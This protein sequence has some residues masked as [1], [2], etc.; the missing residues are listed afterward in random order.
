[1]REEAK[2]REKQLLMDFSVHE[3]ELK[4]RLES[5]DAE[6]RFVEEFRSLRAGMELEL[7]SLREDNVNLKE[8]IEQQRAEL[9]RWEFFLI[10]CLG[11][12]FV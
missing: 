6:L 10:F 3:A 4:A 12:Y 7:T 9:E 8:R 2:N 5:L 11:I 1:M